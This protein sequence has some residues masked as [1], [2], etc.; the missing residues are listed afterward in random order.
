MLLN[1]TVRLTP[2]TP[3]QITINS[4]CIDIYSYTSMDRKNIEIII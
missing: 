4:F 1:H 3:I 2:E